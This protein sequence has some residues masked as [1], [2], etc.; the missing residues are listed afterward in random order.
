MTNS[1][2]LERAYVVL[3]GSFNPA[4]FQPAWFATH[5]LIS[6]D[7]N[8]V[9]SGVTLRIAHPEIVDFATENFQIQVLQHRVSVT[10]SDVSF[11]DSLKDL[12]SGTFKILSHTPIIKMGINREFHFQMPSEAAWNEVGDRLT[13][14]DDWNRVLDKPG[15]KSVIIQ[16]ERTDGRKGFVRVRVGPSNQV[17]P[18]GV[19]LEVNDHFQIAT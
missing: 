3:V 16:G 7:E 1:A 10:T 12:V 6:S 8:K 4:I 13:P 17:I 18:Y 15:M 11:Y 5:N 14:K 2:K 19:F 9:P